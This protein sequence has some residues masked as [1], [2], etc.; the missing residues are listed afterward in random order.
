[1]KKAKNKSNWTE[2]GREKGT[3]KLKKEGQRKTEKEREIVFD[4]SFPWEG[5]SESV[6]QCIRSPLLASN[7][8]LKA[9]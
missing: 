6:E 2:R 9:H 4:T 8:K 3:G 5:L 7:V 1:M